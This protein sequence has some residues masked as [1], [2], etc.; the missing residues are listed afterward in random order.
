MPQ[1]VLC[2][3]CGFLLYEGAELL[4]PFQIIEHHGGR[5]PKCDKKLA[6]EP[7][8]ISVRKVA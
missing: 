1:R 8:E 4:S 7:I 2:H 6:A 3:K 5:C